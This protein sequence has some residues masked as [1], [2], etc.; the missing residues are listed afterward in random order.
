MLKI[1]TLSSRVRLSAWRLGQRAFAG[2]TFLLAGLFV[3]CPSN[4]RAQLSGSAYRVLGQSDLRLN[5]TNRVQGNELF[6]PSGLAL[7]AGAGQVHLYVSDTRNSRVL[8]WQDVRSYRVGDPP[9]LILGQPN[10]QQSTPMGIGAKGFNAPL[11]LAVDP[12]NGNLYTVDY[13][14]N[15]VLR[16]RAPFANPG[17]IEPDALYGQPNFTSR[18]ANATGLTAGSLSQPRAVA[19]DPSGNLWVTDTGNHRI[20]RFS[21]SVLDSTTPPEADLVIGQPDFNSGRPNRSATGVTASGFDIPI[22]LAFDAQGNLYVSDSNNTRVLK[23]VAPF[24]PGKTDTAAALVLGE[25]NFTSRGVPQQASA[26]TLAGPA[27]ISL[28][29]SGRLYVAVPSDNRVLIFPPGALSGSAAKAV[30]GQAGFTVRQ[31]NSGSFPQAGAGTVSGPSAVAIDIDGDVFVADTGNNRVLSFAASDLPAGQSADRVWGQLDLSANGANQIKPTS[32]NA[33]YKIAID[34]SESPFALY[35]SDT[36]NN[37]VLIWKDASHFHSGD[38]ADLVIGQPDL[39]TATANTDNRGAGPSRT[40][41]AGPKGLALDA[42]G[43]LYVADS[44]NNRVLHFPRPVSQVG[45][46]TPDFVIGQPDFTSSGFVP[47]SGASLRAPAGVAIGPDGNLFAADSGN[48]RVLEFPAGAGNAARSIRCYGQPDFLSSTAPSAGATSARTLASPQGIAVDGAFNLYVADSGAN[49]VVIFPNTA[50]APS[51]GLAAS[52]VLGQDTFD[53]TGGGT[54]TRLRAPIDVAL[55]GDR[56]L[57]VSDSGSN[58]VLIFP[59]LLFLPNT[60]AVANA[61]V[62][63]RD[64][65]GTAPNW[66]TP[67]GLATPE[68]IYGPL[69]IYVDRRGTLYVGDSGNNRVMHFLKPAVLANAATYQP[70]VPVAQGGLISLFGAGLTDDGEGASGVPWPTALAG[71]EIVINDDLK[72]PLLYAS[73]NQMNFQL[74]NAS[75]IGSPRL[76]IRVSQTGELVASARLSVAAASPGFFTSNQDGKGQ[77]AVLNQDGELNSPANPAAKGSIITLFGTG[78][79]AVNPAVPDGAAAPLDRLALTVA[80]P[81][82]DGKVCLTVQSSVCVAVGSTFGDIPFSGLAPGFVGLWQL[83]V[84]IPSN[85]LSGNAIPVRAVIN[86]ISSNIVT[87]AIK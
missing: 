12:S 66:N 82:S 21:A 71:R 79:G 72:A 65:N 46:I 44:G 52:T 61:V 54:G 3:T 4:L 80:S 40:S 64:T 11:G 8:A 85:A 42:A 18:V 43:N 19:F 33:A 68:G 7:D 14:N 38:P 75:P 58:R 6:A 49:R 10:P 62:G 30:L 5:G 73:P 39:W 69:G 51:T 36:N 59:S 53:T 37:R 81:T 15:R 84:K 24:Q 28:D 70:S 78:Q 41:L 16:Y 57:F 17:R 31:A 48:N 50:A 45:R 23:F 86:G 1:Q 87:V 32:I 77:G 34:Y 20:L 9:A 22:G 47:V 13:G 56:N 26:S 35:V 83:N 60:N 55:D 67:D 74:P 2:L 29:A 63:Q 76:A 27:G 25:T